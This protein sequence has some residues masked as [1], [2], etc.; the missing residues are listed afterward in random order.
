MTG[1][2]WAESKHS[3]LQFV[4]RIKFTLNAWIRS[5]TMAMPPCLN[6]VVLLQAQAHSL[7]RWHLFGK[8]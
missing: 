6:F 5:P 4:I 2:L 1:R 3:K 8:I 7:N